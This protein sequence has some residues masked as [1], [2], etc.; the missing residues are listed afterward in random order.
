MKTALVCLLIVLG[1][2]PIWANIKAPG[3]QDQSEGHESDQSQEN[4]VNPLAP[5]G[6]LSQDKDSPQT[7]SGANKESKSLTAEEIVK[8]KVSEDEKKK[9]A[10]EAEVIKARWS[11]KMPRSVSL[12]TSK[13]QLRAQ[14]Y[15]A[16]KNYKGAISVLDKVLSRS[17]TED[18]ERAKTLVLMAQAY[19]SETKNAEAEASVVEAIRLESLGYHEACDALLF[20]AQIQLIT[21]NFK[22]SQVNALKYIHIAPTKVPA[23]YIMLGTIQ[24]ELQEFQDAQKS[25]ETALSLTKEPQETWLFFASA[26][27]AKNKAYQKSENILKGLLEKRQNNK[28]YW[29]ALVGVLFEQEKLDEALRYYELAEKSGL[30][31]S[32]GEINNRASLFAGLEIPYKAAA[33]IEHGLDTGKL[34]KNRRNYENLANNW[35]MAREYEKAIAAYQKASEK[36]ENGE[37]DILLGQVY[38]E[39][40]DWTQAEKSF[41]AALK[42]GKLKQRE[43]HALIGLGMATY[44][45]DD[46]ESALKYFNRAVNYKAQKEAASKWLSYLK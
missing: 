17:S 15:L 32:T 29:M 44:F 39:K 26:V 19:M 35:F 46:K 6:S 16:S 42:K 36:S 41:K 18:Y 28:N 38:L 21:R 8:H 3:A 9:I 37:I 2:N 4:A 23:A 1:A 5:E 12:A 25:V 30:I 43:G 13:R 11:K 10:A 24:Y 31:K 33:I 27:F 40:E 20:L 22:E 7:K 34:E 14:K 45:Q